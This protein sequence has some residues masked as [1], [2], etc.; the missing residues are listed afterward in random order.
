M[1]FGRRRAE[2][3]NQRAAGVFRAHGTLRA[4]GAYL[5]AGS[6]PLNFIVSG[7]DE[8]TRCEPLR[9][10]LDAAMGTRPIIVIH[11]GDATLESAAIDC[12]QGLG[13]DPQISPL[14]IANQANR[15]FEPFYGMPSRQVLATL[16]KLAV[17]LGYTVTPRFERVAQAHISI[18]RELGLPICL[19]GF[20]YL[21]SFQ[22]MGEFH[23]NVMALPCGEAVAQRIWVDLGVDEDGA[24]SQFDLFRSVINNLADEAEQ[25][26][27]NSGDTIAEVT[28][29]SA[30]EHNA[31]LLLSISNGYSQ[32]L[33]SYLAMELQACTEP[34]ILVLDGV[35]ATGEAFLDY[36]LRPSQQ[37]IMG[38]LSENATDLMAGDIESF[39]RLA[40][41]AG[42]M[43]LF[44][45]GVGSTAT[46]LAELIGRFDST[47]V[48]TT[49]GT[50]RGFF[51]I[52]PDGSHR[53][54]HTRFEN[55]FRVMPE[56]ITSLGEL[57][58]IVFDVERDEII[59]YN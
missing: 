18:L 37:R 57:Q 30:M 35:V 50:N 5:C 6:L 44:K 46:V 27:W 42:C 59:Y 48:D 22:D 25:S 39:K 24:N 29:M 13:L 45:H 4:A 49:T 21:T 56:D 16:R 1:A 32:L 8:R 11:A 10:L 53:D 20:S 52:L 19:T 55:R 28:C 26:A 47:E 51:N 2:R 34:F 58:A 7:G 40:E 43:M 23:D 38:V 41:H 9:G 31:T 54:V 17:E 33:L 14:V 3:S 36:L 12:W 15:C